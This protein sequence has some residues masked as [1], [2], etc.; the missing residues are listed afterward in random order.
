MAIPDLSEEAIFNLARKID[1]PAARAGY[2]DQACGQNGEL[3]ARL[4]ALLEVHEE[5]SGFLT[6]PVAVITTSE[7]SS[8]ESP[9]TTIGPYKL[10]EQIGEGGFGVVFMAQ[11]QE[12]IRRKVALKVL[13]PGMD[14]RQVIARFEAER[15]A[16][17][18]M[19]HPNIAKVLDAGQTSAGRPYFVMDLV[20]GRPITDYCD[21]NQFTTQ[22]RLELFVHVCQAVQHAHQKGIIHRDIK[23]TNVLV[24]VQDGSPL[25]KIIDFGIAKALGQQLTDKTLFTGFAQLLG[26]PLY[27]SPEQVALSNVDVDT[28]S[29]IYSLG[30]LLYELLTGTTPFDKERLKTADYDEIRRIIR[31]E[32]PPTPSTRISTMGEAASGVSAQRKSDPKHLSRLFRG[33]L[34]WIVIKS[35]EKDRNRRYETASALAADVERYLRDEPVQACP[36]SA[37]YRF[38][39]FA[40]RN[41]AA[42]WTGSIVALALA[43]V[44][45]G[46]VAH[47]RQL[48]ETRAASRATALVQGLGS[49]DI[50]AVPRM[51]EDLA[52]YRRW[53]D[54]L[55]AQLTQENRAS[56]KEQ[57]RARLALVASDSSQVGPLARMLLNASPE[58]VP[59]IR[60]ALLPY[61]AQIEDGLWE[62]AADAE[63]KPDRRLR[64]A[65]ALASFDPH[66]P[67][68]TLAAPQVAALLVAENPIHLRLW[69]EGFAP[70][71]MSL[72]EPLRKL[73]S[74]ADNPVERSMAVSILTEYAAD[75]PDVLAGLVKD[76]DPSQ[77]AKMFPVLQ[78]H[79]ERAVRLMQEELQREMPV[80]E[81]VE[82][83]DLLAKRQAQAAVALLQ[84]GLAEPAWGLLRHS[85]DPSRRTYLFHDLARL[86]TSAETILR[87]LE[88]EPE[89]SVRRALILSLGEFTPAR[90]TASQRQPVIHRLLQWYREDP[91][92]GIHSAV[93]WLLRHS[94]Q[95]SAVRKIDW[96]QKDALEQIDRERAGQPPA[97]R[98][99]YVTREGHTLAVV[100]GP[101]E[102]VMG[103]PAYEPDRE[104]ESETPHSKRIPRSF[105][106]ATKEV[107]VAQ[108]KRFLESNPEAKSKH[109]YFKKYSPEDDGP[110]ISVTWFEAAQYCNWLSKR[111][112]I[113][114]SQ[115]SYPAIEAVKVGMELPKD[116]LHRTGY[117]LPTEAEWE[118]SCRAGASTSRFYGTSEEMLKEY[119]WYTKTTN[120]KRAW[121]VGQLKPNDLGLFDVYGNVAEWCQGRKLTYRPGK[122]GQAIDDTE[123]SNLTVTDDP[124]ALRGCGF[125]Y[126]SSLARSASRDWFRP[127]TRHP[128]VGLRVARTYP[129]ER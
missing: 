97:G 103:S 10:L 57:L 104:S 76:A 38:R 14:T 73:F 100:R 70:I 21:Q 129:F 30:V 46:S 33:E 13:K 98:H 19:D 29:D 43:G 108:F 111:E 40:R 128:Q 54:P 101:T 23:P 11:Q 94:R 6:S 9:G 81:Q 1:S 110:M 102:F 115:W 77:Y 107:T 113:P 118:Y 59:V 116:Y 84:L 41:P 82:D 39:K 37:W 106:I 121:P 7:E 80:A 125:G 17:A 126:I 85:P 88:I 47:N 45:A 64:A 78:V 48:D 122:D 61:R 72:L 109:R 75:Q 2:L 36:P 65:C 105:A 117:R 71:R 3:R 8:Q 89:V 124:R 32:E 120:D 22:Q 27:M 119:A 79:R 114:E 67:R 49:A 68:W 112:G 127:S 5:E 63:A 83:R 93:D 34:D 51:I 95:G 20:K 58:E 31:E 91:D 99:W 62:V 53:A 50:S 26:T 12:P 24:T 4:H 15:Q 56:S 92:A 90:L 69:L 18:I 55:L 42:L 87:Q 16:L 28:R 86:G 25:V 44:I 96:Q 52:E 35:L 60:A 66:S 74:D 123:E